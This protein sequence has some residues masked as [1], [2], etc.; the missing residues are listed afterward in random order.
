MVSRLSV[1]LVA[2]PR[3]GSS[4]LV[5]KLSFDAR[6]DFLYVYEPC[7]MRPKTAGRKHWDGTF[8]ETACASW[9]AEI[10]RCGISAYVASGC[11]IAMLAPS[12]HSRPPSLQSLTPTV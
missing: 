5:G 12:M 1:L 7:R 4:T 9:V 8:F 6:K 3:S 11:S 10:L 2:E